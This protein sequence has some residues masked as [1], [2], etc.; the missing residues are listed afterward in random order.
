MPTGSIGAV[1]TLNKMFDATQRLLNNYV[2][3]NM[4]ILYSHIF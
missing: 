3:M 4:G 1:L 2:I